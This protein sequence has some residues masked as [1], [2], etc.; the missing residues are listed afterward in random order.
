MCGSFSGMVLVLR[1]HDDSDPHRHLAR[2]TQVDRHRWEVV[3]LRAGQ[4]IAE[5]TITTPPPHLPPT[6]TLIGELENYRR[7]AGS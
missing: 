4:R 6:A 7:M 3:Y 5:G 2:A 1:V